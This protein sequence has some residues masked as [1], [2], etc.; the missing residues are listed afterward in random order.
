MPYR[1][2][3]YRYINSNQIVLVDTST[4]QL[5]HHVQSVSCLWNSFIYMCIPTSVRWYSYTENLCL[6]HSFDIIS[7]HINIWQRIYKC[8]VS[9]ETYNHF[10]GLSRIDTH[11]II[12]R[13]LLNNVSIILD[14]RYNV[15]VAYFKYS[16]VVNIFINRQG[17]C[18][19][20][21]WTKNVLALIKSPGERTH[22]DTLV[23]TKRSRLLLSVRDLVRTLPSIEPDVQVLPFQ[24]FCL[25]VIKKEHSYKITRYIGAFIPFV[26]HFDKSIRGTSPC[27]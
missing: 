7:I 4:F 19:S 14:N 10:F 9:S 3:N 16:A 22:W 25:I 23:L 12:T 5:I 13:P 20:L 21:I 8:S 6:R 24:P 11:V 26:E 15:L 1:A 2:Y 27:H 18:K 17:V